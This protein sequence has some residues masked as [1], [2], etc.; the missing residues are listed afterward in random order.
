MSKSIFITCVYQDIFCIK[1]IEKWVTD[2]HLG[3][4]AITPL[5]SRSVI[6]PLCFAAALACWQRR[7]NTRWRGSVRNYML[8]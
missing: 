5:L 7:E 4:V 6:I 8:S 2:G 3:N 1:S